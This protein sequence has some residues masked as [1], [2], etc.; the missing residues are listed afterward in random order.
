VTPTPTRTPTRTFTA[1]ATPTASVTPTPGGS[2][3][4]QC[5]TF[6][7]VNATS[8]WTNNG[9]GTL[10]IRTTISKNFV[11]N[12]YGTNAIGWPSGHTFANLTGSDELTLALYD[13]AGVDQLEFQI[14]YLSS[15][16]A[17]ASGYQTLCVGGGDGKMVTGSATNIVGCDTSLDE[18]FNTFG[19]VLTTNSPATDAS[20]T[21]NPSFPNWIFDVWYQVTVKLAPF[22]AGGGFKEPVI[23]NIHAS[24]SKK[25]QNT[26]PAVE[27]ACP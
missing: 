8:T 14:D 23:T 6:P 19:Y 1:S 26:C 24:P 3:C 22:A 20:Y 16:A 2:A 21:P 5:T 18:N 9:D 13:N 15:S 7:D 12:T 4:F 17:V 25:G 11:D 10:T 27:V